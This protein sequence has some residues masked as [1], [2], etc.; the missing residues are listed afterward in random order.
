MHV[1]SPTRSSERV[2]R[3]RVRS[4]ALLDVVRRGVHQCAHEALRD[5]IPVHKR[6]T[7]GRHYPVLDGYPETGSNGES[8][9]TPSESVASGLRP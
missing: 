3:E 7:L 8:L 1:C 6:S 9:S 2:N 4:R 5:P